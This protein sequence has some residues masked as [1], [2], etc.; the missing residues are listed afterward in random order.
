MRRPRCDAC[1]RSKRKC[2]GD[3]LSCDLCI[4]RGL[5]CELEPVQII[6]YK[7]KKTSQPELPVI[8]SQ[9]MITSM[10]IELLRS[11]DESSDVLIS[12]AAKLYLPVRKV[13]VA[14]G[15]TPF[16]EDETVV[17]IFDEEGELPSDFSLT[18]F[19][20]SSLRVRSLGQNLFNALHQVSTHGELE[21]MLLKSG[22]GSSKRK[23]TDS[24]RPWF[25]TFSDVV[26]SIELD[27]LD[28]VL[29]VKEPGVETDGKEFTLLN[30]N[31]DF[32]PV[33]LSEYLFKKFCE[34]QMV[35]MSTDRISFLQV[36][37][38][39]IFGN[40]TVLESMHI[41]TFYHLVGYEPELEVYSDAIT[42]LHL[43]VLEELQ[44]RLRKCSALC[45]D[46]TILLV[47]VLLNIESMK[48]ASGDIYDQLL[49]IGK[50]LVSFRG[51][52]KKLASTLTGLCLLKLLVSHFTISR[53]GT[54]ETDDL[55][56]GDF[57]FILHEQSQLEFY[58]NVTHLQHI[59]SKEIGEVIK[60]YGQ[61]NQLQHLLE[62]ACHANQGIS[63]FTNTPSDFIYES[64]S[65]GH[66]NQLMSEV[67]QLEREIANRPQAT[68]PA[69][70]ELE[71]LQLH[72]A[73]QASQL[74]ILQTIYR[75]NSTSSRTIL[76]VKTLLP[77]A[78]QLFGLF[79]SATLNIKVFML[80]LFL[81]GVDI[82]GDRNRDWYRSELES[83]YRITKREN[84]I[85]AIKLLE[86]VW[87]LNPHGGNSVDWRQ[88]SARE[89]LTVCLHV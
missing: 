44:L 58:D 6:A 86:K 35:E 55:S 65:E 4:K 37:L 33:V 51:G 84:L 36:C 48:G 20:S 5:Q 62:V 85:T 64:L 23:D 79:E 45:C 19:V 40:L 18:N 25:A 22:Y 67:E 15:A 26:L 29:F 1:R 50:A 10:V 71:S 41:L 74:Y 72:F 39:L 9:K 24:G 27:S 14:D 89:G 28:N 38:P 82:V 77:L 76:C 46:H 78:R 56:L 31:G 47:L 83:V 17:R 8:K 53:P 43:K 49:R 60:V 61:V 59:G 57:V 70:S 32:I 69:L 3:G 12:R 87:R 54:L 80:P 42:R 75:T 63:Q 7:P 68:Y 52:V 11:Q 81:L 16:V 30:L 2:E 13:T 34:W 88:L 73:I 21:A 66:L